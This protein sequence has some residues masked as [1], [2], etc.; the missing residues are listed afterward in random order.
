MKLVD[1]SKRRRRAE[2]DVILI[3]IFVPREAAFIVIPLV[4]ILQ[5]EPN[6]EPHRP[7]S[8]VLHV[9]YRAPRVKGSET[10]STDRGWDN[11]THYDDRTVKGAGCAERVH[12]AE[13]LGF[14]Q[15]GRH[16]LLLP[17]QANDLL[18]ELFLPLQEALVVGLQF[19]HAPLETSPLYL[20]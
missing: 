6:P 7:E 14:L 16:L 11:G 4:D 15:F 8:A 20:Y 10:R 12:L 9:G 17:E 3:F 18:L 5:L 13:C 1:R 2:K 19:T